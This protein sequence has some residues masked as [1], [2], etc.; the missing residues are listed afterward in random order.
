MAEY[1]FY[2]GDLSDNCVYVIFA[3][4]IVVIRIAAT[5][6]FMNDMVKEGS[7]CVVG[8]LVFVGAI[9]LFR[10]VVKKTQYPKSRHEPGPRERAA[11]PPDL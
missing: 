7:G 10:L 11:P 4:F 3:F 1:S 6:F 5:W 2:V 9:F 8:I